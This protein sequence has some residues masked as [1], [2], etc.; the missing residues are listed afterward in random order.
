MRITKIETI[1]VPEHPHIMWIRIHTDEGLIGLGETR[2]RP[3][4]VQRVIHDVLA[5]MLIGKDPRDVEG[6]WQDMYVA[7][8]FF[9][10]AGSEMRAVSGIDIALWDILGQSCSQPIYRLLG[11]KSREAV[12][13]YNTCVS[14]GSY[15]DRDRFI[16]DPGGLAKELLSEGIRAMK[17]WPFDEYSIA[18][19]GQSISTEN[20]K[21][22]VAVI[23][24]IRTAVG[25]DIEIALEAHGCWNLPTAIKICRAVEPYRL[26]WAEDVIPPDNIVALKQLRTATT[27]PLC[28]SERLF[29]RYQYLPIMQQQAADVI[30]SDLCWTGGISELKKIASLAAA[31]Q[32]PI[33]PHNCGGPVQMLASGHL[34]VN[35]PNV[36]TLETVRSFYRSYYGTIVSIEPKIEN[37]F[38]Y[39]SDLPGLG[40][41]LSDD[42]LARKDL[43]V[44]VTEGERSVQWTTG[45]P[46]KKQTK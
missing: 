26:M 4:S 19:R 37:G 5:G 22:G 3:T 2:P 9:G 43:S 13:I 32:L 36:M 35:V 31:Y 20:L 33:A 16:E 27:T 7:L 17:V 8:N 24:K 6:L 10:Y 34:C 1:L 45:D 25:D 40:T 23:E 14:Y 11:G 44:E 30:I 39:V 15:T 18:T 29:T 41:R 42:F 12:P 21:K 28:V 46:W 38:L